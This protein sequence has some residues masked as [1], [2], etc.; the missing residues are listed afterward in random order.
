[1]A[2]IAEKM[3]ESLAVLKAYQD[4]QGDHLVIQGADTL[5]RVHTERL[6]DAGYLKMV[7]KGW[8][9]PSSPGSEGDSTVWY[10]SYWSFIAAYLDSK[11]GDRWCLSPEL[12][13]YYY[14]GK[15]VIPKQ[16]IVRSDTG[17]NNVLDLPFG[18]SILDIKATLPPVIER[19]SRYGIRLYPL[20]YA[21]L[22]VG[23]D[24]YRKHALEAR[25]CLSMI[26]DVSPVLSAA[27]DGGHTTR[28]GRVAG[29]LRS[30][31]REEQADALLS[32]MRQ[33]GYTVTEENPF[34]ENVRIDIIEK[35]PYAA[36]IKLMWQQMRPVVISDLASFGIRP[37]SP[38]VSSVLSMMDA[39]YIKDSYHSLSIEGYKITEGLLEKVRGGNWDPRNDDEDQER[40]NALAARGYYQAYQLLK[41]SVADALA[42]EDPAR[43]YVK[44]HQRWH[45]EL[46]EPCM[47][48]GIIKASD[49]VGYRTHQ[50]Y[51]RNSMHVPLGPAAVL[52]AMTALSSLM[53]EEPDAFVRAVLGHF[54]FVYIHPYM[55]GNGR[56]ARFTMNSQLVTGGYPWLVV[57]VER[58]DEYMTGLEKASV[59]G[60]I[61]PF[62][63]FICSLS[64]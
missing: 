63:R 44:N 34:E 37:Q 6:L 25:T 29:A 26:R 21:L 7:I 19:D 3:A 51:I 31:G 58:R 27:M 60:D 45:F 53:Q 35:S 24:Y 16:L 18:T 50:V 57:P 54:F 9:I 42:G 10:V 20:S 55:D 64:K 43:M 40:K 28:A 38:D 62:V 49:L 11:F 22:M 23:P 33:V 2:T 8:Y 41:Q 30:I 32:T 5:G 13:L 14:S 39:T 48:A 46:F 15:S 12:S 17:T 36:R 1:M 47:R 52:D 56:T 61:A 4:R 59:E